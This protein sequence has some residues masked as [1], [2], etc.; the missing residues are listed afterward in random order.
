LAASTALWLRWL[1]YALLLASAIPAALTVS[2]LIR[3]RRARYYVLRRDA[4]KRARRHILV[5]LVLQAVAVLLLLVA[6]YLPVGTSAPLPS[7]SATPIVAPTLTQTPTPRPSRTPTTTPTRRPTATPPFIPTPTQAVP[8]PEIAMSPLPSAVPP[9]EEALIAVITLATEEDAAGQPVDPGSEF[10]P[11][12]HRV[13]LFFTYE[14][15]DDGVQTTFAWY[16]DEEFI[17]FCSDTWLWGL[18]EGRDWGDSGRSSYF[19]RPPSGWE[20]GT[21]EIRVFIETRLQGIA[22]F[23][24]EEE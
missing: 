12:D 4:L 5:S 1:A 10:S 21:Y 15:M 22:P 14:G 6:L 20:P 17:D 2:Q 18:V 11:G 16:K 19:C 9:G 3:A 7:P 8:P 23:A 13:Y 24:I